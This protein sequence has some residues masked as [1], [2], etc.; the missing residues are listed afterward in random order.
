[1]I[2]FSRAFLITVA[3]ALAAILCGVQQSPA[4]SFKA[5]VFSRTLMFRH[6]SITNGI[7]AIRRLGTENDFMAEA[8]E[9]PSV[10]TQAKLAE[11]KVVVFLSTSGDILNEEQQAAFSNFIESGGG[12]AAIHAAVAGDVATEGGWPWYGEALCA[13]FTNH[14]AIVQATVQVEDCLDPST[15]SLPDRWLRT[16]EWYNFIHSPRGK[17]RVLASLDETTYKGGTMGKDHPVVWSRKFGKGRV[18]YTA[19]GHT[20]ESFTEPLFLK[21]LLGG[22][23]LAAGVKDAKFAP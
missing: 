1:M 16:D 13:H 17:A 14:S 4:E 3:F 10:F 20:E 22:I 5:L 9:D 19:L 11:Y 18:W 6:A 21:H 8:T 7:A 15:T 23:Q 2:A 12:L